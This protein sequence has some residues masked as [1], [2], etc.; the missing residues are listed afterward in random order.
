MAAA[1]EV[2]RFAPSTTGPAHPGTLL[3]ALL[4]WLDAR[5]RAGRI[6]LR[7]E[8]LDPERCR[9]EWSEAMA[10]ALEWLGLD[11]DA[12]V[13]QS[14]AAPSHAAAL[15]R[16]AASGRLYPCRCTRS[17]LRRAAGRKPEAEPVYPG[18]C[19]GRP[20]PEAGWREAGDPL[21]VRLDGLPRLALRD[22]SGLALSPQGA[23]PGDPVV[24]RRDGAVA[25]QLASVVDDADAGVTR[26]V[27]GRDLAAST[28]TQLALQRLLELPTPR[29]RHHLLLLEERGGKLAKLHGAVGFETLRA[30][31]SGQALCGWLAWVCGVADSPA[32]TTPSA[33]LP[34]FDWSRVRAEDAT[35]RWTG[36]ALERS[37]EDSARDRL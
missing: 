11:W 12:V 31:Y 5:S 14:G 36:E 32:P 18:T 9:P 2:G 4:C 29:Y 3:A 13:H 1:R 37:P 19:R 17:E 34:G 20:L 16:L 25:Y 8:D 7:L 21:R 33:L 35:V 15:D 23:A 30:H 26:V 28:P 10:R 24:R 27:R 22:E 6:L